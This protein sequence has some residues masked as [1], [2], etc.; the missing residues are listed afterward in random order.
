[1]IQKSK[2]DRLLMKSSNHDVTSATG[3]TSA[4]K[5]DFARGWPQTRLSLS[6]V[7][8]CIPAGNRGQKLT[9]S[10]SVRERSCAYT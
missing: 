6:R 8:V 5:K 1:M 7:D 10:G 9:M 2:S 4:S 3:M